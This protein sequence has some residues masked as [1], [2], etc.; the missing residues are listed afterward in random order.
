MLQSGGACGVRTC[1]WGLEGQTPL[2]SAVGC[3]QGAQRACLFLLLS[4]VSAGAYLSYTRTFVKLER[5]FGSFSPLEKFTFPVSFQAS[6]TSSSWSH[7]QAKRDSQTSLLSSA[8]ILRKIKA[9]SGKCNNT[10]CGRRRGG[11][12]GRE[13]PML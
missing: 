13:S 6:V 1:D 7:H 12:V 2:L 5:W 10:W 3:S 9:K 4:A 8:Q 11:L